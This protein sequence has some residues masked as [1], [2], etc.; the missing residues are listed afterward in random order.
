MSHKV[1][2]FY[3]FFSLAENRKGTPPVRCIRTW[4]IQ[5]SQ[6][7]RGRAGE[8][9]SGSS[10]TLSTWRIVTQVGHDPGTHLSDPQVMCQGGCPVHHGAVWGLRESWC[11]AQCLGEVLYKWPLLLLNL[12]CWKISECSQKWTMYLIFFYS[13]LHPPPDSP[14]FFLWFSVLYLTWWL[15][16]MKGQGGWK[17][18]K[19][20]NADSSVNEK[21]G[22]MQ[23][24]A[25][26]SMQT[27][28]HQ[29]VQKMWA[30]SKNIKGES[31][32]KESQ[33]GMKNI[34]KQVLQV[35]N[36]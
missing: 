36:D 14:A 25:S 21:T 24:W 26:L 5:F 18:R 1:L 34:W 28:F 29:W 22:K 2:S 16:E 15:W 13:I 7:E 9:G 11:P 4:R 12:S 32:E 10:S 27:F 20:G 31:K 23:A 8:K 19:F 30:G 3:N 6:A 33:G 35:G 17:N